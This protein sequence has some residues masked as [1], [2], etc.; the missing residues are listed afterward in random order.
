MG[1]LL[2]W[3]APMSLRT[4]NRCCVAKVVARFEGG[5]LA[6]RHRPSPARQTGVRQVALLA[7]RRV[8]VAHGSPRAGC[9]KPRTVNPGAACILVR[10]MYA[11]EAPEQEWAI[12][13][14]PLGRLSTRRESHPAWRP[15][16]PATATKR[17]TANKAHNGQVQPPCGEGLYKAAH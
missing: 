15:R 13:P 8:L 9:P 3:L 14:I 2:Q 10:L 5:A 4:H 6:T 17:R 1:D 12:C 7:G 11:W 16:A